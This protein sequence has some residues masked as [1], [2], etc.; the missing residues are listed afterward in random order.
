MDTCPHKVKDLVKSRRAGFTLLELIIGVAIIALIIVVTIPSY[1][2]YRL[3]S[4]IAQAKAD[5]LQVSAKID[6]YYV[7]NKRY[8]DNLTDLSLDSKKDPWGNAYRYLNIALAGKNEPRQDRNLKP[9]NTDYDLYSMGP[10]G[11]TH[12]VFTSNKGRDDIVR[13]NN[14]EYLGVAGDY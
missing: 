14:G 2:E 4:Q 11:Q 10:N 1:Q 7:T 9:V 5:L 6:E 13:A 8:P 12:R 3:K